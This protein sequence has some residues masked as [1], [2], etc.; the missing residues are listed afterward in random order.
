MRQNCYILL[1]VW[2]SIYLSISAV[3]FGQNKNLDFYIKSRGEAYIQIKDVA[4]KDISVLKELI[5]IDKIKPTKSGNEII[6]YLND[7]KS[8]DFLKSKYQFNV[9]TPPSMKKEVAM[10]NSLNDVK[11]WSCYPTYSQYVELMEAFQNQYPEICK[12]EEYGTSID[13][14]KL[15]FVKISDNVNVKEEE[16]E[17]MYSSTMHGDETAGYV[18]MLRLIDYLLLNYSTDTRISDLLNSTEIWINPLSNPDGT[19]YLSDNDVFGARRAN[20]NGVDLN[21]NF[22]DPAEGQHPDN[23]EWQQENVAMMDFMKQH[24]F[25]LSANFHGGA[26]VVNYPWDTWYT[27]HADDAWYQ[28]ISREYA[29]TVHQNCLPGYLNDYQ[30]GIT[31]G[32]DWYVISGGRQDYVNYYLN[33]REV[34]IEISGMKT[35]DAAALPALWNY[36]YRSMLNYINRVHTGISGKVEDEHGNP[37]LAKIEIVNHDEDNSEIYTNNRNGMYYRMIESGTYTI[38]VSKEGYDVSS[39]TVVVSDL[40]KTIENFILVK[41]PTSI[42][43]LFEKNQIAYNSFAENSLTINFNIDGEHEF[44]ISIFDLSGK[45]LFSEKYYISDSRNEINANIGF[46]KD[47]LYICRINSP[48]FFKEFKFVKV[49]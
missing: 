1:F 24:N 29:D 12:L 27:R 37:L 9:L 4:K 43:S 15:L 16:P 45:Y 34:T 48:M 14:R 10:C 20:K 13:G 31:N 7:L 17:F 38:N 41:N 8:I 25:T 33:G 6:G 40:S 11:Q 28:E 19:Y 30:N 26:E 39:R 23:N 47:G 49:K 35:P 21:R 2:T 44:M 22:P 32:A 42:Q 3:C 5:S 36:N 18:L 46:L